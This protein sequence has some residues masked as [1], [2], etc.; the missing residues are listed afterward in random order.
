MPVEE[1]KQT[2]CPRSTISRHPEMDV[3]VEQMINLRRIREATGSV[4]FG[5]DSNTWPIRWYELV[6]LV[7]I[8]DWKLDQAREEYN[9]RQHR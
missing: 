1:A 5:A 3:M 6:R 9:K 7:E 8:E 2:E 4:P